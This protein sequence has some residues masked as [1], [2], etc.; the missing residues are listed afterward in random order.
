MDLIRKIKHY[1]PINVLAIA[2]VSFFMQFG[3]TMIH[4]VGNALIA[5]SLLSLQTLILV[6]SISEALPGI[7]K[8]IAGYLSDRFT[9]RTF[10]LFFGYGSMIVL[11]FTFFLSVQFAI[12]ALYIA[13]Q[14]ID[15]FMNSIRDAPKDALIV[16]STN[17][18]NRLIS[19]GIRKGIGSM[20]T[21]LGAFFAYFVVSKKIF[22]VQQ[23]FLFSI[24]PV[25]IANIILYSLV[26]N[27]QIKCPDNL[28]VKSEKKSLKFSEASV[29]FIPTLIVSSVGFLVL[30]QY[31][32][33]LILFFLANYCFFVFF[34]KQYSIEKMKE[35]YGKSKEFFYILILIA[36]SFFCRM[37]DIVFLTRAQQIGISAKYTIL[38]F[39]YL[40]CVITIVSMAIPFLK[41]LIEKK[42]IK[43]FTIIF[44]NFV[45]IVIANLALSLSYSIYI[46]FIAIGFLG[47]FTAITEV[48]LTGVI[49]QLI[50]SNKLRGTFFGIL[51]S[52]IGIFSVFSAFLSN[53]L[54]R[55]INIQK[56]AL[57]YTIISITFV[58]LYSLILKFQKKK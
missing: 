24:L 55:K 15:R 35:Y 17:D 27:V 13:S 45:V 1:T 57:I 37:N 2:F 29:A 44:T 56:T 28:K 43:N 21:I 58:L 33:L 50:P 47:A 32:I 25:I 7:M 52:T 9:N 34:I 18:T 30:K 42:K 39:A 38:L 49:S 10:F 4:G 40:Y 11:K 16:D 46:L 41:N 54:I 3:A 51:Y 6:R 48:L 22:N 8:V 36:F 20:G 5:G 31:K 19:F 53:Y 14:I 26:K 12:P 23:I